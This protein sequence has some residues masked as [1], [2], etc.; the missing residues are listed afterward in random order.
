MALGLP[1]ILDEQ[2]RKQEELNTTLEAQLFVE[3]ENFKLKQEQQKL[4]SLRVS[5]NIENKQAT[6][7]N[8]KLQVQ[9]NLQEMLFQVC[10]CNYLFPMTY[11]MDYGTI[12][13][14]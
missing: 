13:P 9:K 7:L 6:E 2:L 3:Q 14:I 1:K 12:Q 11:P 8:K 4:A 5:Q 10:L